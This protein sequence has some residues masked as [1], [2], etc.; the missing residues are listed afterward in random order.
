MSIEKP[1][2]TTY[3]RE[4]VSGRR[5]GLGASL[6]R[7]GFGVAEVP[8]AFFVR[9]RNARYDLS[10]N[11]I[12]RVGAPVV[13]VGNLTVGGTGKSPLVQRLARWFVNQ[14]VKVAI[15][16]RG[17]GSRDGE[18]NDEALELAHNLPNV[19][20]LQGPNRAM[21][22][23][24]AIDKQGCGLVLL[25]DGFQ[26]RRLHRDLDIVLL[27]ALA[28]FGYGRLLPRG[29]L[30]EPAS[31]LARAH[32]VCL[33]RA[34]LLPAPQRAEIREQVLTLAPGAAWVEL[35]HAPRTLLASTGEE[36][37]VISLA[38]RPIAAFCGIGN[39]EG[40]RGTL[41]ACGYQVAAW[42]EFPDHHRYS[43][44]DIASLTAWAEG[45]GA[46][47]VVSTHKDLVKLNVPR[48]GD[49]PLWALCIG[50]EV[51]A[52]QEELEARLLEVM[53]HRKSDEL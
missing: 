50:V 17:Y 49:V 14:G 39:P 34:D 24:A 7:A 4:L 18:P 15:V 12:E 48:L 8:Y 6:L 28:P 51:L 42:R 16:S 41:A 19:P 21:S 47:A 52:G 45:S 31:S 20:H 9:R 35:A 53:R 10:R 27:D 1:N 22:A 23:R 44:G 46:Q 38:D 5:R 26:H 33:S 30:R 11:E 36:Q 32:I 40:F 3:F 37:A 13:S 43:Q 29:L 25:D 2:R